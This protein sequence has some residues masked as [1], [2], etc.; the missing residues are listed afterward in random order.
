MEQ[1]DGR[2]I[3]LPILAWVFLKAGA[4]AFGDT[5]PLL[6]FI[7]RELIDE[8]G[9]LTREDVTDALTYD[10]LLPGSTVVQVTAY[11]GYELGGW[12]G[13]AV[14]AVTYLLPGTL[15][16]V[17]LA[18]GYVAV[19]TIPAIAPAVQ[20]LTAA[21]VGMLLATAYRLGK[22]SISIEQ[23]LTIALGLAAFA[24]GAAFGVNVALIVLAAGLLG[25]I[26]LQRVPARDVA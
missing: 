12:A 10:Q 2:A 3:S 11:L 26:F 25:T 23:P 19:S 13:A 1:I 16:M 4:T 24:A 22:R 8:R 20:G 6:A 9:V 15:A 21:A 7:E 17:L 18:A 14:A 5:G